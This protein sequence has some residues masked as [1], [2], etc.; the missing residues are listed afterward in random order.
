MDPFGFSFFLYLYPNSVIN[1]WINIGKMLTDSWF[2]S[3]QA[4]TSVALVDCIIE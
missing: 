2:G 1:H 4:R 3:E